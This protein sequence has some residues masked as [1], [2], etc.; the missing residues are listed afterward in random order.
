MEN[1]TGLAKYLL[2]LYSEFQ[3]NRA[4]KEQKWRKN[5]DAYRSISDGY[6][7]KG[8]G[9]DW[10]SDTFVPMTKMK[11]LAGYS[12]VIDMI[13]QGGE[14]PFTLI[15]SPYD[16]T[17]MEEL[18]E[19]QRNQIQDSI[20][21]ATR[22]IKQQFQDC[23]ADRA[24]MKHI[25][26]GAI[27]GETIAKIGV[28]EVK[29]RGWQEVQ[30]APAG[31]EQAPHVR[32]ERFEDAKVAPN[33][34]YVSVWDFWYDVES[35]DLQTGTGCIQR[36]LTSAYELRKL[37]GQEFYIDEAIERAILAAK[38][39]GGSEHGGGTDQGDLKP[40]DREITHRRKPVRKLEFWVRVPKSVADEFEGGIAGKTDYGI[41]IEADGNEV[42]IHAMMADEEVIRYTRNHPENRPYYRTKWE[43]I[44]DHDEGYGVAD[45]VAPLQKPLNGMVRAFEDNKKLSA[46][47]LM[48]VKEEMLAE[49]DGALT[50]GKR[51]KVSE[52]VDDVR[53]ALQQVI[54]QDVGQT[55]IDGIA[56]F[57]RYM[58]ESSHIPKI[59]QGMSAEKRKPDTLG[60]MQIL[61]KSAGTYLAGV[62]RNYDEGLI[63]PIVNE[64]H[65]FNMED[66]SVERG[67]GNFIARAIGFT[68]FQDKIVR[69]QSLMQLLALILQDEELRAQNK[70]REFMREIYRSRDI[71]PDQFLL[72]EEE[73]LAKQQ[74][75]MEMQAMA[76]AKA[77]QQMVAANQMQM[78]QAEQQAALQEQQAQAQHQR[79]M[80]KAA[81]E[82]DMR[83]QEE[84]A[85][86][87][88]ELV[89]QGIDIA[90][91]R[92]N[93]RRAAV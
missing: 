15:P 65:D 14:I 33:W 22:N 75:Q 20:E 66:P 53:K 57:E 79:D 71:D 93:E 73:L 23:R 68:S 5:L 12:M 92:A 54:I 48:A 19:E 16:M 60:E 56:L 70:L 81:V 46:N 10:R 26:S 18:P 37:K 42:E 36:E 62:I 76:E 85:R 1:L 21:D 72:T 77:M 58:D 67:K 34:S 86:L 6:W 31:I 4:G 11:V 13:L 3:K 8:E 32:Y 39:P 59:I 50:P 61:Y 80:E 7:K 91:Q 27:F 64:F 83:S 74:Q 9:E 82:G 89:K 38:A 44:L 28:H 41:D 69:G 63:E 78:Q 52:E 30:M 25:L 24:M 47:V 40:A 55:L 84:D 29:R 88:G 35:E 90:A 17:V 87:A 43:E 2:E 49:K 45:N 51:I